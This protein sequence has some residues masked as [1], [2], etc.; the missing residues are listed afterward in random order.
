[1]AVHLLHNGRA[2][3]VCPEDPCSVII[4]GL[5]SVKKVPRLSCVLPCCGAVLGGA[6]IQK[7]GGHALPRLPGKH[8]A[9][10]VRGSVLFSAFMVTVTSTCNT[11]GLRGTNM[12]LRLA[13]RAG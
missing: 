10:H 12:L 6:P 8:P 11:Q 1:V 4:S 3:T 2:H 5:V 7:D 13:C 9:L